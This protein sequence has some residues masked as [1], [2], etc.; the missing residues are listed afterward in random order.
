MT[1]LFAGAELAEAALFDESGILPVQFYRCGDGGKGAAIRRLMT[2]ILVDAVHCYEAGARCG[3][4][5]A[6][7]SEARF[8]IF[9]QYPDFPFSFSNVCGELGV[10]RDRIKERLLLDEERIVAGGRPRFVRPPAIRPLKVRSQRRRV[11]HRASRSERRQ[12]LAIVR[13]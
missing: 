9:G 4:K 7:A 11:H 3:W 6:E 13:E 5:D 8:W 1:N 12:R 10:S 2:A